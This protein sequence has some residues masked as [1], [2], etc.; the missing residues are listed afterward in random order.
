MRY[1]WADVRAKSDNGDYVVFGTAAIDIDVRGILT[2]ADALLAL[3]RAD[4]TRAY[5]EWLDLA[6]KEKAEFF[7][8]WLE[9]THPDLAALPEHLK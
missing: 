8:E 7:N 9:H 3:A 6:S 5:E 2:D 4:M 1:P